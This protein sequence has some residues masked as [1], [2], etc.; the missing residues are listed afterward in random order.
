MLPEGE[1]LRRAVRWVSEQ[2]KEDPGT[3]LINLVQEACLR[4]DLSPRDESFL[5]NF[6]TSPE[7]E[8]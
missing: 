7:R 5:V 8:A 3:P 4:F 2:L 1:D 6:F